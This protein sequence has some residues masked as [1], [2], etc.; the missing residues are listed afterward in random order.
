MIADRVQRTIRESRKWA[1]EVPGFDYNALM[2]VVAE[3][4]RLGVH[5]LPRQ[6]VRRIVRKVTTDRSVIEFSGRHFQRT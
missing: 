2:C 4:H 5:F 3:R 6:A 1:P